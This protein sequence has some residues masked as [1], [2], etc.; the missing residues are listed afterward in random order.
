MKKII[1]EIRASC[2]ICHQTTYGF[3]NPENHLI[4]SDC[5][6]KKI[7]HKCQMLN[8]F[9]GNNNCIKC[10]NDIEDL[11]FYTIDYSYIHNKKDFLSRYIESIKE[12][13][14]KYPNILYPVFSKKLCK[15]T[16]KNAKKAL[17]FEY[18]WF[19][20]E[21]EIPYE[22][23]KNHII[24]YEILDKH[25]EIDLINKIKKFIEQIK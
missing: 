7:C 21:Y 18:L 3:D 22:N 14:K 1:Y 5:K 25:L 24:Y 19:I 12:A 20:I 10:D 13:M 8:S 17:D 16:I 4:E 9:N 11:Y 2:C 6:C 23:M 15:K